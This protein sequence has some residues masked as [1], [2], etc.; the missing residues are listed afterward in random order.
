MNIN[1]NITYK[2]LWDATKEVLRGKFIMQT[3]TS[4]KK[5]DPKLSSLKRSIKLRKLWL[6]W[7]GE[8]KKKEIREDSNF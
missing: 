8:N 6:G 7:S 5:K 2:N 3:P 4:K 1:E